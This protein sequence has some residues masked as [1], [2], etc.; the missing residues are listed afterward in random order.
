MGD[1]PEKRT[2]GDLAEEDQSWSKKPA[3]VFKPLPLRASANVPLGAGSSFRPWTKPSAGSN[4]V[5]KPPMSAPAA[6]IENRLNMEKN[7]TP[8]SEV[9]KL[10]NSGAG[11]SATSGYANADITAKSGG[12]QG[13]QPEMDAKLKRILS[14]R[15]SAQK[16]RMKKNAHVIDLEHNAQTMKAHIALLHEEIAER[17]KEKQY[18]QIEQH[19]LKLRMA[20]HEKLRILCEGYPPQSLS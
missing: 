15:L 4:S 12:G 7:L 17:E 18:L 10:I 3:T 8:T 19:Q 20:A 13:E 11:G 6:E 1:L 2:G 9:V 16:F 5:T 14:N